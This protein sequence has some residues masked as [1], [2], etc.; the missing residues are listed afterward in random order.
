MDLLIDRQDGA[1]DFVL[2]PTD[3]SEASLPAFHHALAIGIR[4]GAQFT[5]LHAV[6]RRA[7]DSWEGFPSVRDTLARWRSAG[8][9]DG[10]TA[11]IRRSSVSKV[12]VPI[13]DPLAACRDYLS[14]N[15]V[16][17]IVL[18]TDGRR[19]LTRLLGAPRAER[20]AREAARATLFVPSGARPFVS[21]ETGEVA[22]RK[23]LLPVT[24]TTDARPS[25]L[26]AARSAALVD[27]PD[28]E[29]TLLHVGDGEDARID[30][31]PTLP[32][33]RWSAVRRSGEPAEQILGAAE[34]LR[35]DAIYMAASWSTPRLGRRDGAVTEAVLR[36]ASCP[37]AAIPAEDA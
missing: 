6:G 23:I 3:L 13:P 4:A 34:E 22:L 32:F 10:L 31:L 9:T 35:S 21:G 30:Q 16:D 17:F 25:M 12:E 2:H 20:L 18:A 28:V 24:S 7:T 33:C 27:D 36:E 5:L 1:V 37:V 15:S 14:R 19:G 29:I 26:F 11:R 8:S